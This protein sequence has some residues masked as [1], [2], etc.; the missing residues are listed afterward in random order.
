MKSTCPNEEMIADYLEGRISDKEKYV[1]EEHISTCENCLEELIMANT[2]L[3]DARLF[4]SEQVP[5][6]FT[7]SAI[8]LTI[9]KRSLFSILTEKVKSYL[10]D[11]KSKIFDLGMIFWGEWHLSP[12]RG[13]KIVLNDRGRRRKRFQDIEANIEIEKIG[14]SY[15]QIRVSIKNNNEDAGKTRVT[16]IKRE[17]EIA[18][19]LLDDNFVLFENIAFDHYK[20]IFT[21]NGVM[22]GEYRFQIR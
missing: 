11:L 1:I 3:R 12:V 20:L 18:S 4:E 17:R 6:E 13:S 22:L 21:R 15:A 7:Q 19:Y 5:E 8:D 2:L 10:S 9:N 16:L 14:K